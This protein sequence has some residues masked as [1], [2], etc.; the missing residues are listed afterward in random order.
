MNDDWHKLAEPFQVGLVQWRV[1]ALSK[2]KHQ[3]LVVPYVDVAAVLERL[4]TVVGIEGWQ[5]QYE[6]ISSETKPI[7]VKCRLS[8]LEISKEDVG[9]GQGFKAAFAD[10]LRRAALK[11]GI[12]RYL[13]QEQCWVDHDPETGQFAAPQSGEAPKT[14]GATAV[15]QP[16]TPPI[17]PPKPEPQELIDRLIERLKE[18]GLGKQA[19]LIVTK[20]GG[21]GKT[22]DDTRR[23]YAELRALLKGQS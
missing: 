22:S 17:D 2:D 5:D 4:D 18:N 23:L 6:V 13:N 8:I 7:A 20:Y 16:E 3:A 19:A 15:S 12:G 10:A 1:E 21:Y 11:F 14:S 9:E